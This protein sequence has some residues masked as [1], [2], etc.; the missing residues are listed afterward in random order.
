MLL[1]LLFIYC[2]ESISKISQLEDLNIRK[3]DHNLI[4]FLDMIIRSIDTILELID[5]RGATLLE[6]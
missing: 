5:P 3:I 1:F 2:Q 4:I 6:K